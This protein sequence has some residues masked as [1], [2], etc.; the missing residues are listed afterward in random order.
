MGKEDKKNPQLCH[1]D[2][3]SHFLRKKS[4]EVIQGN[5]SKVK[6]RHLVPETS[7]LTSD[8]PNNDFFFL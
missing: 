5:Y 4:S 3:Y 1:T 7:N 6:A 2:Q 8:L